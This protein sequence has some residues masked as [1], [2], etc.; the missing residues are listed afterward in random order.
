MSLISGDVYEFGPYRLDVTQRVFTRDG[1]VVPLPPKTFEFLLLLVKSPGRAFSKQELMTTLWPETFVEEANLSFQTSVLRKALGGGAHWLETIPKHGY[2]FAADVRIVPSADQ[3]E[4]ALP[5]GRRQGGRDA[6]RWAVGGRRK[7]LVALA[8]AS[9]LSLASY[10]GFSRS[11]TATSGRPIVAVPLT[12]YDGFAMA[13]AISPDGSKVAFSWFNGTRDGN[14]DIYIRVIGAG[15]ADRLTTS[16]DRDQVPAWSPDGRFLAFMRSTSPSAEDLLIMPSSGG[17]ERRIATFAVPRRSAPN[18]AW[19]P[20]GRWIVLG[21]QLAPEEPEGIWLFAVDGGERRRLT[22]SPSGSGDEKPVFSPDGNRLAFIRR[23]LGKVPIAGGTAAVHILPVSPDLTASGPPIRV[24][25]ADGFA[26]SHAWTP[27]GRGLV[28]SLWGDVGRSHLYRVTLTGRDNEGI[29]QPERL[30]FGQGATDVS[31]SGSGRL[32]YTAPLRDSA[33]WKLPLGGLT[34]RPVAMPLLSSPFDEHTPDYS[35][36]GERIAFVSDRSGE[37]AIWIA[38]SD[39]SNP[40]QVTAFGGPQTSNPQWSP[41]G[42]TILFNSRREGSNDL[43]LLRPDT[44]ELRRLTDEP[45]DERGPRWSRDGLWIYFGSNRT[46]QWEVWRIPAAGGAA[47]RITKH[48]GQTPVESADGSFLYYAKEMSEMRWSVWRMPTAGGEETR[49]VEGLALQN[50]FVVAK[51]G[52][53][54]IAAGENHQQTS[55]DFVEHNTGRRTTLVTL[56]KWPFWGSTLSP[57]ER[58]MLFA[59]IDSI[60]SNLMLVDG[61]R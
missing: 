50:N 10:L 51:Q 15:Q 32:V 58:S 26:G 48:G 60:G 25:S 42:K 19:T 16:P 22:E 5:E 46:G 28:F 12:G 52:L 9:A 31:I 53:Y 39:G 59:T 54:F 17:D 6:L 20:D 40:V 56:G 49:I 41:D 1:T 36:D 38:H 43:Y 44:R 33:I 45:T 27:D 57:D 30:A 13:P 37:E 8:V 18:L 2:R 61:F 11:R 35:P 47:V 55:V 3:V 7:W 21:R 34:D 14:R 4:V 29:G 24:T 23:T